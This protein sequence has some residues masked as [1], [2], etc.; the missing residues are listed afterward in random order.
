M[1]SII[2]K[3]LSIVILIVLHS[4][5]QEPMMVADTEPIGKSVE[6]RFAVGA[7]A[8]ESIDPEAAIKR[9]RILIFG[10]YNST[11]RGVLINSHYQEFPAGEHSH[12]IPPLM[13]RA[14]YRDMYVIANEPLGSD[15]KPRSEYATIDS[16]DDI[17]A[18]QVPYSG[19][20]HAASIASGIPMF[21]SYTN[22]FIQGEENIFGIDKDE[23]LERVMAKISL[24]I[25]NPGIE[26]T[27]DKVT[28][29]AVSLNNV[30]QW[31][32]LIPRTYSETAFESSIPV[33]AT[34]NPDQTTYTCDAIYLPE[35]IV[36]KEKSFIKI[37]GKTDSGM[38]VSW[39]LNLGDAM[40]NQPN[41]APIGTPYNLSRNMHYQMIATI[42]SY[43]ELDNLNITAQVV[44]WKL[45]GTD[46]GVGGITLFNKVTFKSNDN[47]SATVDVLKNEN[48][49]DVGG[50]LTIYCNTNIGGWYTIT[51]DKDNKVIAQSTP[52]APVNDIG[53]LKLQSTTIQIPSIDYYYGQ[54]YTVSIHHP[55]Y[56]S[57]PIKLID[58]F[59]FTQFGG[60]IPNS[61]LLKGVRA[62]NI[63]IQ[64][65]ADKLPPRGLQIAKMG[66]V[67]PT[68][69]KKTDDPKIQFSL[70]LEVTGITEKGLGSGRDNYAQLKLKDA[71]NY[72]IG[73]ACKHL[74][75]EWYIPSQYELYL[76][77]ANKSTLGSSYKFITADYRSTTEYN[78]I[79]SLVVN[80]FNGIGGE[81]NKSNYNFRGRCVRDI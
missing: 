56:T 15:G 19:G 61:E 8:L 76:I 50:E 57:N 66:N 70:K 38:P 67:L 6:V 3:S 24:T 63:L 71:V 43:G 80:F 79:N 45:V 37:A 17:S 33:Q 47:E 65:P 60:F 22:R 44:D 29:T 62:E 75:P 58:K 77:H 74:G 55:V 73:Q 68:E 12:T 34:A 5:T 9:V 14:G 42:K 35:H 21:R 32:Y 53:K 20:I 31:S 49:S 28:I 13:I 81:L 59:H 40:V 18:L 39:M 25:Q 72:P 54:D 64:W 7:G 1:K 4:C 27:T 46:P 30:P 11:D 41:P 51:R 2:Y 23:Q 26:G 78:N 36:W 48:L 10:S 52:T 16:P 69:V